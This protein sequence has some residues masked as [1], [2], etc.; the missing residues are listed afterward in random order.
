MRRCTCSAGVPIAS[1]PAAIPP[2]RSPTSSIATSTTRTSA[3]RVH[4]LRVLPRR[5]GRRGLRARRSRRSSARSKRRSRVGGGQL[6]LQGGHN[7]DLPLDVVRG[8]VPR[9]QGA[10]SGVQAPRAVA[11]RSDSHLAAVAAAGAGGDRPADRGGSRQHSRR[12]RRDS[13]R[14]RP[15]AA[16]LLRQGDGRRVARRDAP[17]ASRRPADDGDDDVRDGGDRRGAP[18]AP[19]AAARRCR[20]RPADSPRSSPGATSPI[21]PSSRGAEATGVD[22][23]RTLAIAR[24]VLDNFDNLQASWVTQGGKVGQLSLAFG[25]ND[26]G[27]VMIEENVVRAAGASYCMDEV[28]IVRNIEDA[29]FVPSAGTCTTRSSAIRFPRALTVPRMLELATARAGDEAGMPA[30]LAELSGAKPRRQGAASEALITYRARG[31]CP[32]PRHP[33]ATGGWRLVADASKPSAGE[34]RAVRAAPRR[35]RSRSRTRG[36]VAGP[37]QRA[38]PPRAILARR[39]GATSVAI[40]RLGACGDVEAA[41]ANRSGIARHPRSNA[42]GIESMRA[43]GVALVG[44]IETRWS[45]GL[46]GLSSPRRSFTS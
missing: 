34:R 43:S 39:G 21:T 19:A 27:S 26:M 42:A 35:R 16:A 2:G 32:S 41:G 3:S 25:A 11:A 4:V 9:D 5:S 6:L 31:S 46:A 44:D 17:R 45:I 8:S 7:P 1:G 40:H 10:L 14:S 36:G 18:R 37:R 13:R 12:R 29:G 22:Y 38:H 20:T 15:Q 24:I 30:E 28:E 33:S 23:L